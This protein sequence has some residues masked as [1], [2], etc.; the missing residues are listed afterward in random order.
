MDRLDKQQACQLFIEQEI[1]SGLAD[2]KTKYTI[3]Q[4]ISEWIKNMFGAEV[5]PH[6]IEQ[7]AHR[8]EENIL[9]NVSSIDEF[10][11]EQKQEENDG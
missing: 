8:H 4:E 2:G 3:G 6:T 7:R 5:K 9:T 11:P 10:T 1:E